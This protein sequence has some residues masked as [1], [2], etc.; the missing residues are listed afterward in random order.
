[1]HVS[2]CNMIMVLDFEFQNTV[3]SL[4]IFNTIPLPVGFITFKMFILAFKRCY[5]LTAR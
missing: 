3:S 4:M 5:N 1:M 2:K